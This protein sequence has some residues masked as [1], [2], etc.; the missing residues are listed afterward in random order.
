MN[1]R[2]SSLSMLLTIVLTVTLVISGAFMVPAR[3]NA[4]P[5]IWNGTADTSWYTGDK[6]SYDIYTAEQLAGLSQIVNS[7]GDDKR[8]EGVTIN[9]MADIYLNDVS[10]YASWGKAAP[11]NHWDPIGY[12]GNPVTGYRPFAGNF[13]GNGHSIWGMYVKDAGKYAGFFGYTS[14]AMIKNLNLYYSYVDNKGYESGTMAGVAESSCFQDCVVLIT[15]VKCTDENAGSTVTA[16][17]FIGEV[18]KV[19]VLVPFLEVALLGFGIA[20]NPLVFAAAGD[21]NHSGTYIIRCQTVYAQLY[22]SDFSDEPPVGGMVGRISA[23]AGI[24]SCIAC[25]INTYS[26]DVLTGKVGKCGVIL[27]EAVEW[28]NKVT[29]VIKDCSGA[30]FTRADGGTVQSDAGQVTMQ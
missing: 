10:T 18:K 20:V 9:L 14:S 21:T 26:K 17:G 4:A 25:G 6:T 3:V 7:E 12:K 11:A 29:Y 23:P 30:A 2:K 24:D 15:T 16:G 28:P 5:A 22:S 19:N 13:N 27:G 1:Y 8:F